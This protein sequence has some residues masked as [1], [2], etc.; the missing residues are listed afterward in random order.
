[1]SLASRLKKIYTEGDQYTVLQL[2]HALI[3]EVENYEEEQGNK[4]YEHCV[5]MTNESSSEV[6]VTI[7]NNSNETITAQEVLA[8]F[9]S[10]GGMPIMCTGVDDS[11]RPIYGAC[12]E[13]NDLTLVGNYNQE[14]FEQTFTI[15]D[16]KDFIKEIN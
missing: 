6:L 16:I 13:G 12:T 1:M 9:T 11:D 14:H 5:R 2:L 15:D 10:Q 8:H 3:K 7:I 4:L